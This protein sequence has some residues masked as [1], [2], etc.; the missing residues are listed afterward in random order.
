VWHLRYESS[1]W[2]KNVKAT[3]SKPPVD[4]SLEA[5]ARRTAERLELAIYA[6][7]GIRYGL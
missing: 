6:A 2:R 1:D 7:L 3:V 4:R 5:R